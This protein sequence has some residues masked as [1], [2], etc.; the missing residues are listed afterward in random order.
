MHVVGTLEGQ[1]IWLYYNNNVN[2]FTVQCLRSIGIE[3]IN[4]YKYKLK[5]FI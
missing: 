2:V 3:K 1:L 5:Y 4:D